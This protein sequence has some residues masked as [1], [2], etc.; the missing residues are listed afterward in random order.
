MED[1]KNRLIEA[2]SDK[3]WSAA[4]LARR[5][6][7]NKGTISHYLHGDMI[8]KQSK[9]GAMAEALGVSPSWLLGFNVS[10]TGEALPSVID[11]DKLSERNQTKLLAYYQALLDTQGDDHGNG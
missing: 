7:I 8:P 5:S 10:K 1:V 3:G 4:E 11:L 9:V 6:G 2:L